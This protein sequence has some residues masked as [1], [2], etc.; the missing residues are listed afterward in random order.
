MVA[1][2]LGEVR[3]LMGKGDLV[4]EEE[5]GEQVEQGKQ[6][7]VVGNPDEAAVEGDK[8][9]PHV[10]IAVDDV[11]LDL[12][13]APVEVLQVG[14]RSSASRQPYSL[15][16][17]PPNEPR[18]T[19]AEPGQPVSDVG[20]GAWLRRPEAQLRTSRGAPG[21]RSAPGPEGSSWLPAP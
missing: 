8:S 18:A 12:V 3:R 5:V 2:L 21:I 7:L 20:P 9:G 17:L 10:G 6:N 4:R 16:L 15:R 13:E 1:V 11:R 14:V 19:R